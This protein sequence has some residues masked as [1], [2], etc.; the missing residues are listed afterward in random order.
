ME[1]T[2]SYQSEYEILRMAEQERAEVVAAFFRK[3]F[4]TREKEQ[5][6]PGNVLPID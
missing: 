5:V 3:L 2:T 4:T 6:F 1:L